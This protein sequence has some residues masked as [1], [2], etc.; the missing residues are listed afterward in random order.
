MAKRRQCLQA[1]A[2]KSY[3][4]HRR[5]LRTAYVTYIRSVFEYGAAVYFT[6][7]SPALRV[8]IEAEQ[9]KCARII[10]GCIRSTNRSALLAEADLP[11]L[12]VRAKELAATE[13]SRIA[14]LPPEDPA[15]QLF[16]RTPRPRL[17]Y[18][19]H[20]AWNR[21]RASASAEGTASPPPPDEDVRLRHKPCLRRV[22]QWTLNEAGIGDSQ[23]EPFL[24]TSLEPPWSPHSG[25]VTFAVDLPTTTRRTD[26]PDKRR[27][28][29]ER[30]LA[31]LPEPDCT[32]WSDG[33]AAGGT[34]NG[35]GG[36][37]AILHREGRTLECLAA[38]GASCSSTRAELVAVR[39]ALRTVAGL[40]AESL[41][42]IREIRLC[43]DSRACLQTLLR[44]PAAQAEALPASIWTTLTHLTDR[45]K[46]IT[47]QWVPGHAGIQGNEQADRLANRAAAELDQ[48]AIPNE[49]LRT[50][51][52]STTPTT[53]RVFGSGARGGSPRP[54]ADESRRC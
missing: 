23:A 9:N 38:A 26:P 16:D 46:N 7:A 19:A 31:A 30:A 36:A 27:E 15:K 49:E 53:R 5:T 12:T 42:I 50:P 41:G 51:T 14:R 33:S 18:R 2:G 52:R 48:E 43:T 29:A 40:P 1:L 54:A 10:T 34:T 25:T 4:A 3:G 47:L 20:E 37:I 6:H 11:A 8:K 22:G 32:I 35:G 45:H 28:A 17:K 13:V 39:A 21:A 44:G 24:R